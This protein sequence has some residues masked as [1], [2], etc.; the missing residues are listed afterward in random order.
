MEADEEGSTC[1]SATKGAAKEEA[2]T[3]HQGKGA[4]RRKEAEKSRGRWS[5]MCGQ[6]MRSAARVE[7]KLSRRAKKESRGAL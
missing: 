1:G 2:G 3:S 4:G 7:E 5:G 6:A